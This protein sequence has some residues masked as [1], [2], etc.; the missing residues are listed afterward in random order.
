VPADSHA[1]LKDNWQRM[2]KVEKN[3]SRYDEQYPDYLAALL[4][5]HYVVPEI[6]GRG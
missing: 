1:D 6:N 2:K 3:I 5:A 4:K